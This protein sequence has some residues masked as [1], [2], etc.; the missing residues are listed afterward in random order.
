[1]ND[2]QQPEA[3][4]VPEEKNVATKTKRARRAPGESQAAAD[5]RKR[6]AGQAVDV[7][8]QIV[9]LPIDKID[10]HPLNP[11]R[12]RITPEGVRSLA[13]DIK[14]NGLQQPIKVRPAPG[15][16]GRWQIIFG[17]RRFKA[18]KLAKWKTIDAR[19]DDVDDVTALRLM[20]VEN[21]Q[22]VDLDAI[23]VA[24]HLAE[25]TGEQKDGSRP[26]TQAEAGECYGI[27]QGEV[28][29]RIRL[30]RLTKPWRQL[31]IS[32]E[33]SSKQARGL[34]A[35]AG[36]PLVLDQVLAQWRKDQ[37]DRWNRDLWQGERF[38][39][40]VEDVALKAV[41]PMDK[42]TRHNYG[43]PQGSHPRYFDPD[44]RQKEQLAIVELPAGKRIARGGG[45]RE[46][47]AVATNA[48][49]WDKLNAPGVKKANAEE[50]KKK[51]KEAGRLAGTS[52]KK[53]D[54]MSAK[55]KKAHAKKLAE[56]RR[57]QL[58]DWNGEMR[59]RLLRAH[60]A[61]KIGSLPGGS[62][63]DWRI[64][65]AAV[66]CCEAWASARLGG[67]L[68]Q[69]VSVALWSVAGEKGAHR[70]DSSML[71]GSSPMLQATLEALAKGSNGAP[72]GKVP[73]AR[74]H[75]LL[76]WLVR[77]TVW[78]VA[79]AKL[80]LGPREKHAWRW[81]G[82]DQPGRHDALPPLNA[83][84]V[85]QLAML[86]GATAEGAWAEAAA[87]DGPERE[88]VR[89]ALAMHRKAELLQLAQEMKVPNPGATASEMAANILA[90]HVKKARKLP[91]RWKPSGRGRA[92][93]RSG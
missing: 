37:K 73:L 9:R 29:N 42:R 12:R 33:I 14:L 6:T 20:G 23:S 70:S 63:G 50:K 88:V 36:A 38:A 65:A 52:T 26:L 78:P 67:M 16:K 27:T 77:L 90:A 89:Q 48:K 17:E 84:H 74:A 28:S 35:W 72:A 43:W 76:A 25:M 8:G 61:R 13:E 92:R 64:L 34:V 81:I 80:K 54:E 41:R 87:E 75:L 7:G 68:D 46:T 2:K 45:R 66:H 39:E 19:V 91:A 58:A 79:G 18:C 85:L 4:P 31:L 22:R 93:R 21:G 62:P 86:F 44:A 51:K 55:E 82:D 32:G 59:L 53:V 3:N 24:E 56:Q 10:V 40:A 60:T 49:L 47:V 71:S 15:R 30:L 11:G 1:M 69:A 5:K 83:G 57:Q